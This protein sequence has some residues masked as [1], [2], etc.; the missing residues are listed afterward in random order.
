[1]QQ[2]VEEDFVEELGILLLRQVPRVRDHLHR[3]LLPKLPACACR[4][5][6]FITSIF[7]LIGHALTSMFY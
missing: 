7:H 4:V 2:E 3:R 5:Q 6:M 1:M